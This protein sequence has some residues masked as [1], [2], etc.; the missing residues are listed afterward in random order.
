[1]K[2]PE[3]LFLIFLFLLFG[4]NSSNVKYAEIDFSKSHQYTFV[5]KD[6]AM[7]KLAEGILIVTDVK[8]SVISGTYNF[9]KVYNENFSGFNTMKGNFSGYRNATGDRVFLNMNPKISDNNI[10]VTL[11]KTQKSFYGEWTHSTITG[12]GSGGNFWVY[13]LAE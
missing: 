8:D 1:M 7:I 12:K 6:N 10:F 5:M 13:E 2:R 9:S 4:C 11:Y 3:L